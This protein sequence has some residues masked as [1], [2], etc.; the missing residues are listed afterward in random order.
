MQFLKVWRPGNNINTS[1]LTVDKMDVSL[2]PF[3]EDKQRWTA[4][5]GRNKSTVSGPFI[6]FQ[7]PCPAHPMSSHTWKDC[8]NTPKNKTLDGQHDNT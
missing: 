4:F 2:L 3:R 8:F 5:L 6:D 1:V 7:G